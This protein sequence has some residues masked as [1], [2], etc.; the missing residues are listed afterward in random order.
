MQASFLGEQLGFFLLGSLWSNP[1]FWAILAP[2]L[3]V[4]A[5]AIAL[6]TSL[7]NRRTAIEGREAQIAERADSET[8]EVPAALLPPRLQCFVDRTEVMGEAVARID[9]GERV[10]AIAGGAGVGKS[11]VATELAHRLRS[12]QEGV[13]DLRTHDYLWIDGRDGCPS[14]VDICRQITLLTGDQSLSAVADEAKLQALRAHLARNKM[15]LVL[16]NI[17]LSGGETVEPLRELLRTVPSGSLVIAS[18]NSPYALDG[19]RLLLDE[20]QPDYVLELIRHESRRLGLDENL[21]D[22]ELAARLQRAVGGNP[23]LIESFLRALSGT[24][25]SLDDLLEAVER[26]EGLRELYQPVWDELAEEG[27]TVAGAIACLGGQAIAEQLTAFCELDGDALATAL[28]GLMQAGFVTVIRSPGRPEVYASPY[29]VQRFALRV[30]SPRSFSPGVKRLADHYVRQF[31]AEP[32]NAQW[33]IPHVPGIKAVLQWLFDNGEDAEVQALFASILDVICTLGLFD[34]RISTGWIAY[35]SATRTDNP[36]AASLAV[37]VMTSTHSARGELKEARETVDLGLIA[38]ERSRDPG[39]RARM[40]RASALVLYKE[41]KAEEA[42]AAMEGSDELARETGD[43]EVLVNVWGLRTVAHWYVGAFEQSAAAAEDGLRVCREMSWQRAMAYP[44]RNLAE[45]AIH[46]GDFGRARELVEDARRVAVG[47]W[48]RRQ[49]ARVHLTTARLELFAG[50]LRDAAREALRAEQE[51][52]ELG[53]APELVE[54][55]AM[56]RAITRARLFPP[57]RLVYGRRRPPRFTDA[58]IGGD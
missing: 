42:L 49:V 25:R 40:M 14:L 4:V 43:L 15:V 29:S 50:R 5:G 38:A 23:R 39:E 22:D 24:P 37:D 9:A 41:G 27:R 12:D 13:P 3:G 46:A 52:I 54:A 16:D 44:L 11:A 21:F 35:E 18:L 30:T 51:A 56:R 20:L 17:R 47:Y 55:R 36:R 19:P 28:H 32:E 6:A 53:L 2:V 34:D 33:A 57:L 31:A 10:L 8:A 1:A 58:P 26:G 45:V 48:D 7:I